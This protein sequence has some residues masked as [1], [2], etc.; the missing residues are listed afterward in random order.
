VSFE[1][2]ALDGMLG[3]ALRSCEPTC[4]QVYVGPGG[5]VYCVELVSKLGASTT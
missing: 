2:Y 1:S 5:V 3:N 4:D